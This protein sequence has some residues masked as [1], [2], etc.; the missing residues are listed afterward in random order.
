MQ[1]IGFLHPPAT[2]DYQFV[3]AADD[4]AQLWLSTDESPINRQLIATEP[5]WKGVRAVWGR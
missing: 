3:I 5:Q 4:N 1:M 2:G